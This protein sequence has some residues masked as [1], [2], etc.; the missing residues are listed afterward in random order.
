VP[1]ANAAGEV[2][3]EN[4]SA[5]GALLV[6]RD[7]LGA[8][9]EKLKLDFGFELHEVPVELSL[10]CAIRSTSN[11]EDAG[12]PCHRHGVSFEALAPRDRLALSALVWFRT[13][14]NPRLAV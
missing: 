10:E 4:V 2:A 7:P 14:E 3:I 1:G 12:Q 8:V 6:A 11:C 5:T 13:Y 9:G